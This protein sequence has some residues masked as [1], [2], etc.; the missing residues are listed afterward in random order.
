MYKHA[1][2]YHPELFDLN[3]DLNRSQNNRGFNFVY[4]VSFD[5]MIIL[6]IVIITSHTNQC[7]RKRLKVVL[8][9]NRDFLQPCYH[10]IRQDRAHSE[11]SKQLKSFG[12][13]SHSVRKF[14]EFFLV[15][16]YNFLV[17]IYFIRKHVKYIHSHPG[18]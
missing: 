6:F 2:F 7:V 17:V 8:F 15:I 1:L 11:F 9:L 4:Y 16:N 13:H 14:H 12:T 18:N 10:H 3:H 5:F